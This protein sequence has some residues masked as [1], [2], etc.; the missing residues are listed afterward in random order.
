MMDIK[1]WKIRKEATATTPEPYD[2]HKLQI[3][4]EKSGSELAL[5]LRKNTLANDGSP[6]GL[7]SSEGDA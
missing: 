5:P 4:S 7:C 3:S 6:E 1:T 2:C